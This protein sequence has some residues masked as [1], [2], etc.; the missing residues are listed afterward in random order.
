[1]TNTVTPVELAEQVGRSPKTV[2]A[3]ARKLFPEHE[4]NTEWHFSTEEAD[5]LAAHFSEPR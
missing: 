2:R 4:Q 1:M 5:E 3:L